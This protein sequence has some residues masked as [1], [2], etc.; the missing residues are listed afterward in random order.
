[1]RLRCPALTCAPTTSI[2]RTATAPARPVAAGDQVVEPVA[3]VAEV[4]DPGGRVV[5]LEVETAAR[6]AR[7]RG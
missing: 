6:R 7:F 3:E 1:M 2:P 4:A 5:G